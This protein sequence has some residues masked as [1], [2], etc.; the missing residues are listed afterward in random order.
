MNISFLEEPDL[1]FG[2][3]RHV[4]IR[5]GIMNYGPLDFESPLAPRQ[6]NLGIVGTTESADG[7]REWLERCRTGIPAKPNKEDPA[8]PNKQPNL[9]ARFPRFQSGQR[10]SQYARDAG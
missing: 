7:V 8:K 6:I 3:G 5:F 2:A 10:L 1:E 9:F 4:D